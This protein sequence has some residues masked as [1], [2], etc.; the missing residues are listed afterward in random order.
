[1]EY[2]KQKP[3]I[4]SEA[5][6]NQFD[7]SF[8]ML[9]T[10]VDVCHDQIW[11]DNFND[12]PFWYQ[13]YHVAYFIDY[14]LRDDYD[15]GDFRCMIFDDRI[16]PEFEHEVDRALSIS[17]EEMKE[18]LKRIHTKTTRIFNLL[19]DEKM[20]ATVLE[21]QTH[22]TYTDVIMTQIRH[23]MYN[24]GYLNGILRSSGAEESDWYAYNEDDD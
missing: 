4:I 23:I 6:R 17:R 7:S 9:E 19:D 22:F 11:Y 12:L 18:Y 2:N 13:V 8:V 24:I 3:R 1:M 20:A 15:G 14:W 5:A 16:P 10:L 21:G